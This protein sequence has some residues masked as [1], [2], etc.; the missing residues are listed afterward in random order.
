[1]LRRKNS[2]QN[3]KF[4]LLALQGGCG[5]GQTLPIDQEGN[6]LVCWGKGWW[7]SGGSWQQVGDDQEH[8][9]ESED[10]CLIQPSQ[11]Q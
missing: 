5:G 4:K 6:K 7:S 11:E 9:F 10:N 2:V 1:M 3:L 8:N